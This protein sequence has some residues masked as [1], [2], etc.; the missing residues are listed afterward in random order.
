MNTLNLQL[1]GERSTSQKVAETL[2]NA[3]F[4]GE[5]KLGERLV[6]A[7]IA[8]MLNVSITPVRQAF[9]QLASEGLIQVVPY[10]GT[11]V[12]EITESLINE[13]YSLR[14][15]LELMAVELAYPHLTA[16]DGELLESYVRQMDQLTQE[17]KF[18]VFAEIDNRF[19]GLFYERSGHALLLDVWRMLQSRIR[20]LQ[21]YWMFYS[22]PKTEAELEIHHMEIVNAIREG[23]RSRLLDLTAAHIEMGKSM[24]M[25][26][27]SRVE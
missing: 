3:I 27:Y 25:G 2:R 24:I 17:G 16:E 8:K 1:S 6:E 15:R 12:I 5:L 4:R 21:T 9:H 23:E 26:R 10:K 18:G 22:Q 7:N 19:H 14:L 20:L 11:N 13:V